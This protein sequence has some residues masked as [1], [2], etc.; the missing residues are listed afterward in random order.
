MKT[1]QERAGRWLAEAYFGPAV[2]A[3]AALVAVAVVAWAWPLLRGQPSYP[4]VVA[5]Y[6]ALHDADKGIDARASV[7]LAATIVGV[8]VGLG[9][10]FRRVA[11]DGPSSDVGVALS[12]LLLLSLAP[13]VWRLTVA[14]LHA[15]DGL[16]PVCAMA[17]FP[18]GVLAIAAMLGRYSCG[19]VRPGD[20]RACGGAALLS[21]VFAAF[22][23]IAILLAL[24][25][26]GATPR[27]E[28]RAAS[29]VAATAVAAAAGVVGTWIASPDV[30]H[31]RRW[32]LRGLSLWQLPLPLLVFQLVP[33]P[34]MDP[35]HQFTIRYPAALVATLAACAAAGV[36]SVW[37]RRTGVAVA[38]VVA[39]L[40]FCHGPTVGLPAAERDYFHFGEQVLP[41]EQLR[42]FGSRPYVDF[43][44]VHGLMA[45]LRGG[46]N[47]LFF[48]GT[49]ARYASADA[50]LCGL[51]LAATAWGACR[52]LGP[53]AAL[54]LL[55]APLPGFDRLYLLPAGL[56]LAAAPMTWRRPVRGLVTWLAVCGVMVAY[57]AAIGPAFVVATSPVAVWAARR[58][59]W[60]RALVLAVVV[61]AVLGSLA[62]VPAGRQTAVEFV[63][64]VVDNGWTNTTAHDIPWSAGAWARDEHVGVGSSQLFWEAVRLA[65]IPVA[66]VAA[67]LAW[68]TLAKKPRRGLLPLA[69]GTALVLAIAFPWTMGRIGPGIP[70]RPGALSGV[71][72]GYL[73]PALLLLA[74]P[75]RRAGWAVLA[76]AI[77]VGIDQDATVTDL[78]P[79]AVLA[80]ATACLRVP[81][82]AVVDDGAKLGLPGL[83]QVM[84]PSPDWLADVAELR[85]GLDRLL[86][87]GETYLDLTQQQALYFYL[88]RRVPV[89]YVG[90]VAAN[91]RLQAAEAKQLAE[92]PVPAVMVGPSAWIDGIPDT[93]RCYRLWRDYAL[94]YVPVKVGT[95]TFLV[96]PQRAAEFNG[97][98]PPLP[99]VRPP[100]TERWLQ[101]LDALDRP[102]DLQGLP[103]SWGRSWATL[104]QRFTVVGRATITRQPTAADRWAVATVPTAAVP[105]G[106]AADFLLLHVT[107]GS[108]VQLLLQWAD[109][110]G[111]W[112]A[113][114]VHFGG[115][116]GDLLVPLG[117]YPRW[118][119]DRGVPAVRVGALD[120]RPW[121][122]DSATFLQLRP[123]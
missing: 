17:L 59:G 64:F 4:D 81:P 84:A 18:L 68:R 34:M 37:R 74:V 83:G 79:A 16:P 82:G 38:T 98:P 11:P 114:A 88:G 100:V 15:D 10:A 14:A 23:A 49:A 94:R 61:L 27:F 75:R 5:G 92:R 85:R 9:R 89:R 95:F 67:A 41:W 1:H 90:Y 56:Y 35:T 60:R 48:D 120:G 115:T 71:A 20:V 51:A 111:A 53:L 36:W 118:L 44:P 32:L 24:S 107:A 66:V 30:N 50:L 63:R 117:A 62:A 122:L 57:N 113:A 102:D 93:L 76:I 123:S 42:D 58:A 96:D 52:L 22:S 6:V 39:L 108:D 78:D 3:A 109:V 80:K 12:Q 28:H 99:G 105:D 45:F 26:V 65:W 104:R 97:T 40:V 112:P 25:R 116:T 110:S 47:Q 43:V 101:T 103:M 73:V 8:A 13:A 29:A 87:P 69:V 31:F 77:I 46:L 54:V 121:R 106:A 86:R 21:V 72:V 119:L 55:A 7:L 19:T 70:S 33:P 2:I 91:G